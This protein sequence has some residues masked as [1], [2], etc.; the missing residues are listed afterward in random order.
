MA[1]R[2]RRT[3]A[4]AG[5]GRSDPIGRT[6]GALVFLLG[7]AVL[8]VVLALSYRLFLDP[9]VAMHLPRDPAKQPTFVQLTAGFADL[10]IRILLLIVGS[11][12][13]ALIASR[14]IRMYEA[15]RPLTSKTDANDT[16]A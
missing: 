1:E 15:A 2:G 7:I 3:E 16:E 4:M 9:T 13:G 14:G 5:G 10:L 8:I 11:V 12:C 6:L